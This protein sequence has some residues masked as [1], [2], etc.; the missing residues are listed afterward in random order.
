MAKKDAFD[1]AGVGHAV[2]MKKQT[3]FHIGYWIAAAV[4]SS[5][6]ST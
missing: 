3:W 1:F 5:S 6:L 2:S 4:G